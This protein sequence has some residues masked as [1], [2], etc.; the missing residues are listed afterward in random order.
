MIPLLALLV[1]LLAPPEFPEPIRLIGEGGPPGMRLLLAISVEAGEEPQSPIVRVTLPATGTFDQ[2][3]AEARFDEGVLKVEMPL[4]PAGRG[5]LE[6]VRR[7]ADAATATLWL[8]AGG[9]ESSATFELQRTEL[10]ATVPGARAWR[11]GLQAG[12]GR[13]LLLRVV[14]AESER[15]G[16]V[17]SIDIPAQG[18]SAFPLLVERGEERA[19]R[20]RMVVGLD[21]VM[22]LV[23]AEDGERLEGRFRQGPADLPLELLRDPTFEPAL[24]R[25][26][27]PQHPVPPYPY[28]ERKVVVE[29]P[30]GHRLAGTLTLPPGASADAP[31]AAA[32]LVTGSGPQDRDETILGHK[33]FLVI[34]DALTRAG[35]A[36]LRYDDRGCFESTGEFAGASTLDFASDAAEAVRFLQA[37]PEIDAARVGVIG[38]SEGGI[39]APIVA[40]LLEAGGA[41]V[42]GPPL[43]FVVLLAGPGVPGHE[44]LRVQIRALMQAMEVP[45]EVVDT[46][47]AAQ[48]RLLDLVLADADPAE[49]ERAALEL[50]SLQGRASGMLGDEAVDGGDEMADEFALAETLREVAARTATEMRGPWMRTFLELDPAPHLT[51]LRVPTLVLL[52]ELDRQVDRAQ[53]EPPIRA[54]LAASAAPHE[55]RVLP[56]LNH[57]FQPTRTG[58]ADEYGEIEIT[59][60]PQALAGLVEWVVATTRTR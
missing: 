18:I 21:A 15:F 27:R 25:L 53:N 59:F 11:G 51:A 45:G 10:A 33:P 17:G 34:A 32:V 5:R 42:P 47:A 58:A 29:H 7:G 14:L 38:H 39:V 6:V 48:G 23:E 43:G 12:P 40:G 36:V 37:L 9:G 50:I 1:A 19:W 35:I 13:P 44:I 57:L 30:Q 46:I 41:E 22:E 8:A 55:V 3:A 56:G 54:A 31:V 2:V 28:E 60:E 24:P 49:A 4:G 20:L 26:R 16:P 52:A